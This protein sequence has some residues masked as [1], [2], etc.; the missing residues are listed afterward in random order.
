MKGQ[1]CVSELTFETSKCMKNCDG[2]D[3]VSF[4]RKD[5]SEESNVFKETIM[6]SYNSYKRTLKMRP[7]LS[8]IYEYCVS[9]NCHQN[10]QSQRGKFKVKLCYFVGYNWENKLR[11]VRIRLDTPTFDRITKDRSAKFIDML[12]AIGGTLGLLT[13]FSIVSGIEILYFSMKICYSF[14]KT[15]K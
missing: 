1:E 14:L 11:F 7:T 9:M 2:I 3:I 6:E 13:G 10:R 15:P 5:I 8:S 4:T 12:S